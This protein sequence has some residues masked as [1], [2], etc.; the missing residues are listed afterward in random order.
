MTWNEET[1]CLEVAV[2]FQRFDRSGS[3]FRVEEAVHQL[4]KRWALREAERK[5]DPY[6]YAR[7]L[8][9][10]KRWKVEAR[11]VVVTVRCCPVCRKMFA[12]TAF[13]QAYRRNTACSPEHRRLVRRGHKLLKIGSERDTLTGWAKR[14]GLNDTT[15]TYRMKKLGWTLLKALTTPMTPP[16]KR[17][18]PTAA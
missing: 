18:W 13:D 14:Y 9:G 16:G 11:E 4:K 12:V 1:L 3:W 8:A 5:L 15:V 17:R 2:E 7:Y 6:A 10:Q